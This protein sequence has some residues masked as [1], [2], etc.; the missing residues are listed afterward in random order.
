VLGPAYPIQH[1]VQCQE[2]P[3]KGLHLERPHFNTALNR[4]SGRKQTGDRDGSQGPERWLERVEAGP[5]EMVEMCNVVG[6]MD[7]FH[8]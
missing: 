5:E 7:I 8:R 6:K 4:A 3:G 2:Q 1:S